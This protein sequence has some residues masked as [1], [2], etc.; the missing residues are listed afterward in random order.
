[1][2]QL[3][4]AN[5]VRVRVSVSATWHL[6]LTLSLT[7]KIIYAVKDDTKT[8]LHIVLHLKVN[9]LGTGGGFEPITPRS[10]DH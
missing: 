8:K 4:Q 7:V 1:M 3:S 6:A 5:T 10:R 9:F 2:P